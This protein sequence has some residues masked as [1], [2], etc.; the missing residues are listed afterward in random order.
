MCGYINHGKI[1]LQSYQ[2]CKLTSESSIDTKQEL[3]TVS[4]QTG[5]LQQVWFSTTGSLAFAWFSLPGNLHRVKVWDVSNPSNTGVIDHQ[6]VSDG[7]TTF[8]YVINSH[9]ASQ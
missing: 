9:S 3:M 4:K 7:P 2:S 1:I 6:I 8:I 5:K